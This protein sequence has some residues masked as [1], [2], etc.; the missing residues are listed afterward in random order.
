[1][2]V[3]W[4]HLPEIPPALAP[5]SQRT[6]C[7]FAHLQHVDELGSSTSQLTANKCRG[8]LIDKVFAKETAEAS[9]AQSP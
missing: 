9:G 5:V 2:T 6:A 1:M 4:I 3:D 8:M 7:V